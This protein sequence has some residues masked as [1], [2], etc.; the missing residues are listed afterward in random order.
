MGHVNMEHFV[1]FHVLF[2]EIGRKL[3]KL[4]K[5]L[6]CEVNPSPQLFCRRSADLINKHCQGCIV[7]SAG[8][9]STSCDIL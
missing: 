8:L 9:N 2:V 7:L 3:K 5:K 6:R 1:H 4:L